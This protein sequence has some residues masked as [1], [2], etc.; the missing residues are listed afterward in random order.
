[1][2]AVNDW[3]FPFLGKYEFHG[4]PIRP[5]VDA[6]FTFRHVSDATNPSTG[7]VTVGGGITVKLLSL[8]LSPEIRDTHWPTPAFDLGSGVLK[9]TSNQVDFLVGFSF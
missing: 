3:Q 9:S 8:R 1:M 7:G 2:N 5:F 6:G 4:G